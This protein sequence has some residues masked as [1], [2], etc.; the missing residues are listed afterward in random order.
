[1]P[2]EGFLNNEDEAPEL[3]R[4]WEEMG[5]PSVPPEFEDVPIEH[6]ADQAINALRDNLKMIDTILQRTISIYATIKIAGE[7]SKPVTPSDHVTAT[8]CLAAADEDTHKLLRELAPVIR[9]LLRRAYAEDLTVLK[10]A[11]ITCDMIEVQPKI[12]QLLKWHENLKRAVSTG[13]AE[14]N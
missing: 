12:E 5:H 10:L 11:K 6:M 7:R 14:L 1:M 13:C 2:N 3:V 8:A 9:D 4:F